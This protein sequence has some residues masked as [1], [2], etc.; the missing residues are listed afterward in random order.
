M[1]VPGN[2]GLTFPRCVWHWRSP[3]RKWFSRHPL[4]ATAV[5]ATLLCNQQ[6]LG[7]VLIFSRMRSKGSR[8]TVFARR[9]A[10]VRNRSQPFAWSRYGRA[11]CCKSGHFWR[12]QTCRNL[13]GRR[14]T[15]RFPNRFHSVSKV[16]PCDRRNT[17]ASFS[18]DELQFSW[19]EQRFR[20][21]LLRV[22]RESLCQG[23]VKWWQRENR[24][25]GVGH[26]ESVILRGR[27][28]FCDTLRRFT[29]YTPHSTLH[30]LHSTLYTS[31]FTL[32]TLHYTVNTQDFTLYTWQPTLDTLY[33]TLYTPDSTLY[34]LH[35]TLYT[36]HSALYT[37]CF[38]LHTW[39]LTRR[40]SRL[41]NIHS[42][43]YT[44]NVRLHT[45]HFTHSPL[46]TVHLQ[47]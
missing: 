6:T 10:C 25:A 47:V 45:L 17:M 23:R 39:H 8:F 19:Q 2:I 9:C 16:V 21:V 26:R 27:C 42:T 46:Y 41:Y 33:C 15:L 37:S 29:L 3:L 35:F 12:F 36:W 1:P 40:H 11:Q 13:C 20:S 4:P 32:H 7:S 31:H 38:T 18:E 5:K 30:T 24:V 14:G 28:N 34:T 22:L 44:S 43:L